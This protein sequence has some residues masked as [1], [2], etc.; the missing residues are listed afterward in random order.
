MIQEGD[1]EL[2]DKFH[3][4]KEIESMR[5]ERDEMRKLLEEIRTCDTLSTYFANK[6]DALFVI[7]KFKK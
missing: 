7:D 3:L 2:W 5:V 4:M 6:I 1:K